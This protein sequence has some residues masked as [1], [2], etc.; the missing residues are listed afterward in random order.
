MATLVF[1]SPTAAAALRLLERLSEHAHGTA[2]PSRDGSW[3][4]EVSAVR[5]TSSTVPD[6]LSIAEEWVDECGLTGTWVT[7]DGRTHLLRGSRRPTAA[8]EPV[9]SQRMSAA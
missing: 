6:C 9:P 5:E 8:P 4:V 1:T 3:N 7:L 2:T